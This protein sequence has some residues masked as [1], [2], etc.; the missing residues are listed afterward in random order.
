MKTLLKRFLCLFLIL[1]MLCTASFSAFAEDGDQSNSSLLDLL[2]SLLL[3]GMQ[4]FGSPA[5]SHQETVDALRDLGIEISDST[6]LEVEKSMDELK[7]WYLENGLDYREDPSDFQLY[8]LSAVG[9]GEYDYETGAW[10]PSSD[11]VYYFDAE[12]FDI[13]NMYQLFLQGISSIVP[14]F[15]PSDIQEHIEENL[16]DEGTTTWFQSAEGTTTVSFMLN[17]KQYEHTLDFLGDW[18]NEDAIT[19]I[20]QVLKEEGFPGRIHS[21][22]DGLQGLIL[23]Y[24]DDEYGKKLKKIVPD[25]FAGL[26]R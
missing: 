15:E 10:T 6:V 3:N 20:N 17:G 16:P 18:F 8:L 7:Q 23:F 2:G 9:M 24:G 12:V 25:P 4:K 13:M 11:D 26:F 22:Y 21:F 1:S 14:G 5:L 19:W